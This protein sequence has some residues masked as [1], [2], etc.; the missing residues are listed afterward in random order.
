MFWYSKG[1]TLEIKRLFG[2]P[3]LHKFY[4]FLP[5][6]N[7]RQWLVNIHLKWWDLPTDC[8]GRF[9][10]EMVFPVIE[11]DDIICSCTAISLCRS[12][13]S[14]LIRFSVYHNTT[15]FRQ[16]I[17]VPVLFTAFQEAEGF[18]ELLSFS[19]RCQSD[20]LPIMQAMTNPCSTAQCA[21]LL[22]YPACGPGVPA[23][24][25]H[26]SIYID[27]CMTSTQCCS[28]FEKQKLL[29][30]EVGEQLLDYESGL[31]SSDSRTDLFFLAFNA[32]EK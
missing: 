30:Y 16:K 21:P 17:I 5:S 26:M 19:H 6:E 8:R 11:Y 22:N 32:P 4:S 27:P 28:V 12:D 14:W 18:W 25:A 9:T 23:A 15:I 3:A 13:C 1:L 10:Q 2:L 29:K 31:F 20:G 7:L 24:C